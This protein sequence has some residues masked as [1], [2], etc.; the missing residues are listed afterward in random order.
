MVT[1][2]T[3]YLNHTYN[4]FKRILLIDDNEDDALLARLAVSD[5][6]TNVTLQY[7]ASAAEAIKLFEH[8]HLNQ[9]LPNLV[10]LDFNM[11]THS[12]IEVLQAIRQQYNQEQLPVVFLTTSDQ[13]ADIH[14]A[15]AHG[16]NCF[17]VKPI[18][19][20]VFKTVLKGVFRL[21]L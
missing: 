15:Y 1:N 17:V 6:K 19:Y 8:P 10:L 13:E 14:K 11:P 7:Q 18:E 21:W 4:N 12:G 9:P 3:T 5:I 16:A 20:A 2:K